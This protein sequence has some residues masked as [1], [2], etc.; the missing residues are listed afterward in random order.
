M[1]STIIMAIIRVLKARFNNLTAEEL[2]ELA[3]KIW[4]AVEEAQR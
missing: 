2:V 4:D 3:C 1:N